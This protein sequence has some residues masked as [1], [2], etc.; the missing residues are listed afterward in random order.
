VAIQLEVGKKYRRADGALVQIY[1]MMYGP[2]ADTFTGIVSHAD[3]RAIIEQEYHE[4]GSPA[5]GRYLAYPADWLIVAEW[6]V[7]DDS[8]VKCNLGEHPLVDTGGRHSWCSECDLDFEL[9]GWEWIPAPRRR[10]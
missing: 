7:P 1:S 4:D 3:G 2:P 5:F 8:R 9:V 6:D 10:K